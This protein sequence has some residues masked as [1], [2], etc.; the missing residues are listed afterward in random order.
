MCYRTKFRRFRS[1]CTG[2]GRIP[3]TSRTL[4]PRPLGGGGADL[5]GNTLLP[6]CVN[7]HSKFHRSKPKRFGVGVTKVLGTLGPRSPGM[8]TWLTSR[9]T[10]L[11]V[12]HYVLLYHISSLYRSVRLGVGRVP[13]FL[14][15]ARAPPLRI[16]GVA[17]PL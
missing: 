12:S 2:A 11:P 6:K 8:G 5:P 3:K 13:N 17:D 10:L 16:G 1:D 14:K 9:K 15:G 7:T 4:R